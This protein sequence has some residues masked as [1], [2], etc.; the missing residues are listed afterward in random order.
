MRRT[1]LLKRGPLPLKY[2]FL[3]SFIFFNIFTVF[4]LVII[5]REL[6]PSLKGIAETKARQIASQAIN[7]AIS[8]KI[9]EGID[10]NQLIIVHEYS[11]GQLTFSNNPQIYNRVISEATMRVQ[12]YLDFVEE[13]NLDQ[14]ESFKNDINI[15]YE[16]SK[17]QRGIVY[18]VP[19]GMATGATLFSNL[20]PKIPVRFEIL[21]DVI[22]DVET[23][24]METGINNTYLEIYVTVNVKMNVII[25]LID[26]P[27]EI[28][29]AVKI[30]D[31]FVTGKVPTY[32]HGGGNGS[33]SGGLS[34]VFIPT[35]EEEETNN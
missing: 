11:D 16:E 9:T 20:G 15:N 10:M 28:T 18:E 32:Y 25:P 27:I 3:I 30:G 14:L 33:G 7:D 12:R 35:E 34:P 26:E 19:L 17:K 5:N 21:G 8:K 13:G 23:K 4:S 24:I 1:S 2:V 22:S 31:L 6:E 29:N